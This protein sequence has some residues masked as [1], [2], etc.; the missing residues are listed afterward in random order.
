MDLYLVTRTTATLKTA[1]DSG[2]V[3]FSTGGADL[4]RERAK[5]IAHEN[6]QTYNPHRLSMAMF[7]A[8]A[9]L[10]PNPYNKI[11]G[12]SVGTVYFVP[13][14]PVMAWPMLV[15]VL[16]THYAQHFNQS[17]STEWSVIVQ[18]SMEVALTPM[19]ECIESEFTS[20]KVFS[21]P[22]VA[23][24]K[25]GRHIE[26]GVKGEPETVKKAYAELLAGLIALKVTLLDELKR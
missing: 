1:F 21:L 9:E 8:E 12:F 14:F 18:G 2:D 13:R 24:A 25:Y 17:P 16:D 26:L 3:V 7:P 10:I 4:I 20:I 6:G 22:S 11:S 5:D 15:W 23:H 19:M